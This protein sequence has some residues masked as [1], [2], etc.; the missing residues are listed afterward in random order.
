MRYYKGFELV[1]DEVRDLF[2]LVLG[3]VRVCERPVLVLVEF[4]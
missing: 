1:L 2:E 4:I 3:E